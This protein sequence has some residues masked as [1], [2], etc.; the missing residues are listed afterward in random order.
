MALRSL[1][2]S[3]GLPI[4][5]RAELEHPAGESR[6]GILPVRP[7]GVVEPENRPRVQQVEHVELR[8]NALAAAQAERFR[9]ADIQL[10]E[11][12]AVDG[13][14]LNQLD[15]RRGVGAGGQVAAE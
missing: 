12:A 3:T 1:R 8:L 14:W 9:E 6:G 15:V 11:P 13:A 10:F 2:V 5:L 4:E 7:V